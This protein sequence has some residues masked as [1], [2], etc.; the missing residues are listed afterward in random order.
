MTPYTPQYNIATTNITPSKTVVGQG[1]SMSINVTVENQGDFPETFSVTTYYDDTPI[2]TKT[3][4]NL[5]P[6]EDTTINFT[7][8]TIGVAKGEYTISAYATPVL[9]ETDT[10]DNTLEDGTVKVTVP[11]D[12]DGD[13]E[14][15]TVDLSMLGRAWDTS[16][17]EPHNELLGTDWNPN[18]D[19]NGDTKIKAEDISVMGAHWG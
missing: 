17:A 12:A 5:P 3:V 8:N 15:D 7:W 6:S 16:E 9:G 18:C 10:A 1:Y 19:F 2:E 13:G 11:G 4:T 14:V